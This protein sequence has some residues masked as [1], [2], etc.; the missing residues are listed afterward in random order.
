MKQKPI[1]REAYPEGQRRW[2][3]AGRQRSSFSFFRTIL[4]SIDNVCDR[5]VVAAA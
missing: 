1:M 2:W 5:N 4:P 3:R